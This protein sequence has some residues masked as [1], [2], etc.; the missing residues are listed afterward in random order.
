MKEDL[1]DHES[2][3]RALQRV[4]GRWPFGYSPTEKNNNWLWKP[5]QRKAIL[6]ALRAAE[7]MV[8]GFHY[9]DAGAS[10]CPYCQ[11]YAWDFSTILF[12]EDHGM[13]HECMDSDFNT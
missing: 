11:R 1:L 12:L 6:D 5:I 13:C 9:D 8:I 4:R 10:P 3:S 2:E 7:Q